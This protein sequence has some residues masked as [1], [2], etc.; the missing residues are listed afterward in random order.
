MDAA[1]IKLKGKEGSMF[2]GEHVSGGVDDAEV[3]D[4]VNADGIDGGVYAYVDD[5]EVL[6]EAGRMGFW[7]RRR[8]QRGRQEYLGGKNQ[9]LPWTEDAPWTAARKFATREQRK[10]R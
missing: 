8:R 2:F 10:L 4:D 1:R 6:A 9:S 5:T 3:C 7:R